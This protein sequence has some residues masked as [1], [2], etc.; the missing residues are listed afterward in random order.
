GVWVASQCRGGL[1][2]GGLA[3]APQVRV[4]AGNKVVRRG[5]ARHHGLRTARLAPARRAPDGR[6]ESAGGGGGGG[7]GGHGRRA[8]LQSAGS[9]ARGAGAWGRGGWGGRAHRERELEPPRRER[10]S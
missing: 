10:L 4:A 2:H 5:L 6:P 8:A 7:S 9:G 3:G 1:G